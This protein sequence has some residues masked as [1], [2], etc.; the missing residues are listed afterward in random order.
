MQYLNEC[1]PLRIAAGS[2]GMEIVHGAYRP[3]SSSA[4]VER[5]VEPVE[6][7]NEVKQLAKYTRN[8]VDEVS[9]KA[10]TLAYIQESKYK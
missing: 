4:I 10:T 7:E 3:N 8:H 1:F 2:A 6:F 9:I 5:A